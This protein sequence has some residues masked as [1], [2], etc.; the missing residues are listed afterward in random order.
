MTAIAKKIIKIK[1]DKKEKVTKE[2]GE[3][4]LLSVFIDSINGKFQKRLEKDDGLERKRERR[5]EDES[6]LSLHLSLPLWPCATGR[7]VVVVI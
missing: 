5:E 6:Y 2:S 7:V 4:S 1:K 3:K